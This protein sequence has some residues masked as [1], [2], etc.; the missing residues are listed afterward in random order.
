MDQPG[1]DPGI[2]RL[3]LRGLGRINRLS[4]SPSILWPPLRRLARELF[5]QPLRVLDVASGGGDVLIALA[6]RAARER[7]PLEFTGCDCSDVAVAFA[8]EQADRAG[9]ANVRFEQ[10]DV[11]EAGLPEGFDVIT[12][13]LF[14]HHLS[15]PDAARLL[16]QMARSAARLV[17]INDL[18]RCATGYVA[19]AVGCRLLTRSHIVHVDGPRSVAAAFTAAELAALAARNGMPSAVL[20]RRWPYRM[21]LSWRRR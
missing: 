18:R 5:P 11:L 17:L 10:R 12:S 20:T 15:E 4:R 16:Q 19:A 3:A 2:H 1:L 21:L 9:Q 7:L 6:A 14:L 13:S 8:R